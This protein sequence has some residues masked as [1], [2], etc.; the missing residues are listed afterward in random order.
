LR[1][2]WR[3]R[4]SPP[5]RL[6]PSWVPAAAAAAALRSRPSGPPGRHRV[7]RCGHRLRG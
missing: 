3:A 6:R 2:A 4:P 7:R 5:D 1:A